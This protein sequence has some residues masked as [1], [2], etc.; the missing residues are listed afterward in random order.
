MELEMAEKKSGKSL[1][2]ANQ[3][4]ESAFA[5]LGLGKTIQGICEEIREIYLWDQI[6][7][8]IGYSGGKDS[9]AIL[10]LI[11]IAIRDLP[12]EQRIK[13]VHVISTD[14]LVEQPLVAA[15]VDA[16]HAKMR[17]AAIEQNMPFTPHKLMPAVRDTF[18]VNLIG[19]GYPAPRKPAA[20]L[21]CR[22]LRAAR[23]AQAGVVHRECSSGCC[24]HRRR[25]GPH[26]R[27]RAGCQRRR[28]ASGTVARA[29]PARLRGTTA[30]KR[31]E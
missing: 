3:V 22:A 20:E 21:G 12:S 16:S 10:Q 19:K 17:E 26:I 1:P 23:R 7:W 27:G 4:Q 8:V 9:T 31:Q 15:W 28:R 18:W 14:T 11:W 2:I 24:Y 13:P 5:E 25:L 29:H 6:P 30:S